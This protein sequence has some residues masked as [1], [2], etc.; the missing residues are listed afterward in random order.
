MGNSRWG[1]RAL[2]VAALVVGTG[3][4]V[5]VSQAS[6]PGRVASV[7]PSID[8]GFTP[9]TPQRKVFGGNITASATKLVTI[10][11]GTT[12]VPTN[13][14]TVQLL[15]GVKGARAGTLHLYPAGDPAGSAGQDVPWSA[16]GSGSGLVAT[17]V[18]LKNQVA[19]VNGSTAAATVT[20]TVVGYS[21]EI[22]SDDVSSRGG[23]AGQVLTDTGT[24]AAWQ[25]P[26]RPTAYFDHASGF[27][28]LSSSST[29]TIPVSVAVPG[30]RYLVQ[31]AITGDALATITSVVC[32]LRAAGDVLEQRR[33]DL[34]PSIESAVISLLYVDQVGPSGGTVQVECWRIGGSPVVHE[35]S[36]VVTPVAAP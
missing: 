19:I 28:G 24:G 1:S 22:E 4:G 10:S 6:S 23:T 27:I 30:G 15:I 31:A 21:T 33:L 29:P 34:N 35:V 16:G 3:V 26:K 12:T 25:D 17:D 11:G 2:V 36:L 5:G 32:Q 8:V 7:A 13:A 14:T 20:V 9:V 18:G